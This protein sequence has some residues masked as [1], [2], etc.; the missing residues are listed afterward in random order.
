[1]TQIKLDLNKVYLEATAED[2]KYRCIYGVHEK[3]HVDE[4]PLP[5]H[6]VAHEFEHTIA[7]PYW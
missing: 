6:D 3:D 7:D 5:F 4:Q 2:Q 1:M